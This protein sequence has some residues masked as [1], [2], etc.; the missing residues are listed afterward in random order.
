M[1]AS[2][3]EIALRGQQSHLTNFP[4][5]NEAQCSA[6]AQ[7]DV[8]TAREGADGRLHPRADT[9]LCSCVACDTSSVWPVLRLE[10]PF[11][12]VHLARSPSA[13]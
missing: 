6:R 1:A 3:G 12:H 11:N 4:A 2:R 13:P 5:R 9:V 10:A 8:A 7:R